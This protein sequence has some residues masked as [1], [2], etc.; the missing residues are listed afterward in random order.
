MHVGRR[1]LALKW[2]K[3]KATAA[4]L[5]RY[6]LLATQVLISSARRL[7]TWRLLWFPVTRGSVH[8]VWRLKLA[9]LYTQSMS[10][11]SD[12]KNV[13]LCYITLAN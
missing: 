7:L 9:G 2:L 11:D 8:G 1:A 12:Y 6:I 5:Y 10:V 13:K 3:E 4:C